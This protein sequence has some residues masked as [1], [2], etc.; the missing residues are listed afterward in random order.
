MFHRRFISPMSVEIVHAQCS[1]KKGFIATFY[2][3]GYD[4]FEK[5]SRRI[6]NPL[7]PCLSFDGRNNPE[8]PFG[9]R[10]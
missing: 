1:T 2:P 9:C 7:L 3:T 8:I 6:A 5:E 10:N 4:Q